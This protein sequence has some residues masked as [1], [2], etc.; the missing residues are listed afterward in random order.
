MKEYGYME[1]GYLRSQFIEPKVQ[2]YVDADGIEHSKVI[3]EDEQISEL[4]PEWKPVDEID[5]DKI[6]NPNDGY[7]VVPIPY[8][9]GDRIAYRYET[10][11]DLLKIRKEIQKL[12]NSLGDSDF[13]IMKCYEASLIGETMP[14]DFNTLH[15]E[16]QETRK[17]INDLENLLLVNSIL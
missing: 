1:G 7:V 15:R 14:Y 9:C 6:C 12:K 16:R 2:K 4:S 8:D 13:K 11:R 17:R 3:T 5:H 10:K